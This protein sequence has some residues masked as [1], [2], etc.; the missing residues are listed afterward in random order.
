MSECFSKLVRV[1]RIDL[2]RLSK[3]IFGNDVPAD[4]FDDLAARMVQSA[5]QG[6]GRAF[7]TGQ[8]WLLHECGLV[9]IGKSEDL[10]FECSTRLD[11]LVDQVES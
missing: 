11:S 3:H 7:L 2:R 5:L 4:E 10:L 1:A 6:P 8:E 9:L